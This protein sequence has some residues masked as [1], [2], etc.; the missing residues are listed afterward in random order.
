M[1]EEKLKEYFKKYPFLKNYISLFAKREHIVGTSLIRLPF[2][3][4][5][6]VAK[7]TDFEYGRFEEDSRKVFK[8]KEDAINY[9]WELF[10]GN[11]ELNRLI[12]IH[13]KK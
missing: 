5:Y 2:W 10:G 9:L 6:V 12:E 11:D 3:R 13:N 4:D 7:W 8:K 1:T